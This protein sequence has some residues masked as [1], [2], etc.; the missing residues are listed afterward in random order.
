[1][2]KILNI[3]TVEEVKSEPNSSSIAGLSFDNVEIKICLSIFSSN[4]CNVWMIWTL[5][6]VLMHLTADK[7]V[8][9]SIVGSRLLMETKSFLI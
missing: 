9:T 8:K 1:M 7:S 2:Q 4:D 6:F 3:R 5:D